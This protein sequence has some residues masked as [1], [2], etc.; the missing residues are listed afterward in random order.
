MS[1]FNNPTL[2]TIIYALLLGGS[3]G[4]G[5]WHGV[6]KR[7]KGEEWKASGVESGMLSFFGIVLSFSLFIAGNANRERNSIIHEHAT[8]LE[9]LYNEALFASDS[10]RALIT[11]DV[12]TLI[13]LKIKLEGADGKDID[14]ILNLSESEHIKMRAKLKALMPVVEER[15]MGRLI[16][17]M[18]EVASLHYRIKQSYMDHAPIQIVLML[19]TGSLLVGIMVGLME[20]ANSNG[21]YHVIVSFYFLT[22][23]IVL[24]IHDMDNPDSGTIRPSF[25]SYKILKQ[26]IRKD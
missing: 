2:F 24:A 8:S 1:M 26:I 9:V 18:S 11:Q 16:A 15:L 10:V 14:S 19:L 25:E 6:K 22:L 3:I 23:F 13:E 17:A 21:N 4:F 5:Y 20:G 7:K 12:L